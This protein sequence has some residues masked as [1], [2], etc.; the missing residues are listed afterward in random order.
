MNE[1]NFSHKAATGRHVT[2]AITREGLA[3]G[4]YMAA[5]GGVEPATLM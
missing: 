2:Q 1:S 5:R 3:Q 4:L